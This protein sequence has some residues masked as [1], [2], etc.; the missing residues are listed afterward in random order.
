MTT[1]S[2]HVHKLHTQVKIHQVTAT[3]YLTQLLL[4]YPADAITIHV[5]DY[6]T[7]SLYTSVPLWPMPAPPPC[8]IMQ[9]PTALSALPLANQVLPGHAHMS[10]ASQS[11]ASM[12]TTPAAGSGSAVGQGRSTGRGLIHFSFT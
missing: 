8:F 11:A 6:C 4:R 1:R 10:R 9:D 12:P 7:L 2:D 5:T 3:D